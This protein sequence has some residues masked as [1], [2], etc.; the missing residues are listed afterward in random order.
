MKSRI[1]FE[2]DLN[3][4]DKFKKCDYFHE[5]SEDEISMIDDF[6]MSKVVKNCLDLN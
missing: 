1:C 6:N 3:V 4:L 2:R 5:K